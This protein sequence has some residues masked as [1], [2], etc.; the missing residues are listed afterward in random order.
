MGL[1]RNAKINAVLNLEE[2]PYGWQDNLQEPTPSYRQPHN[3]NQNHREFFQRDLKRF[4]AASLES[5]AGAKGH[6]KCSTLT[7][8]DM[9]II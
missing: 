7:Y 8:I 4:A 9:R 6:S 1:S 2:I 3:S 5:G